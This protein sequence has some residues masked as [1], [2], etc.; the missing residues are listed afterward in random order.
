MADSEVSHPFHKDREMD[1]AQTFLTKSLKMLYL[2]F[3][4]M[5][6][7]EFVAPA[8]FASSRCVQTE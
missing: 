4:T 1:G 7:N 2:A 8:P 3:L 5:R 6:A